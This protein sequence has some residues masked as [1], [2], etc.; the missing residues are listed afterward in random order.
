MEG[1]AAGPRGFGACVPVKMGALPRRR[2]RGK[3]PPPRKWPSR[4]E[5]ELA[6]IR[7]RVM[8]W[9]SVRPD[10][11]GLLPRADSEGGWTCLNRSLNGWTCQSAM[12]ASVRERVRHEI[13]REFALNYPRD[14][15]LRFGL[16]HIAYWKPMKTLRH[17]KCN[18]QAIFQVDYVH[19][20]EEDLIVCK[21]LELR[22]YPGLTRADMC[23]TYSCVIAPRQRRAV[24]LNVFDE[25]SDGG[26]ADAG[27]SNCGP[28]PS[29]KETL[30]R[31]LPPITLPWKDWIPD[32][33]ATPAHLTPAILALEDDPKRR[34]MQVAPA[35]G[36]QVAPRKAS[37]PGGRAPAPDGAGPAQLLVR[38][39]E[40]RG[41]LPMPVRHT[42]RELLDEESGRPVLLA[43]GPCCCTRDRCPSCRPQEGASGQPVGAGASER[44]RLAGPPGNAS[45]DAGSRPGSGGAGAAFAPF[46][47]PGNVLGAVTRDRG[48]GPRMQAAAAS[49]GAILPDFVGYEPE[50]ASSAA[51][52]ASMW[53]INLRKDPQPMAPADLRPT[54]GAA[55]VLRG[56]GP[57]TDPV[58]L[59]PP[60]RQLPAAC[61]CGCQDPDYGLHVCVK[62]NIRPKDEHEEAAASGIKK[63]TIHVPDIDSSAKAAGPVSTTGS[64][65]SSGGGPVVRFP[66]WSEKECPV[67]GLIIEYP[68][69][70]KPPGCSECDRSRAARSGLVSAA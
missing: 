63:K 44:G 6:K 57:A 56:G 35:I 18:L 60:K 67:C 17:P 24:Q 23:L 47:G 49:Y 53:Q 21:L 27:S 41:D 66:E 38:C 22:P 1:V 58:T 48:W 13:A 26:P 54:S 36:E 39:S 43:M 14:D 8:G 50:T 33:D 4:A 64:G 7:I 28:L 55:G 51:D 12:R 11:H 3:Q 2:L 37:A 25:E 52:H 29:A 5:R 32:V 16:S 30:R 19:P 68:R 62:R 20:V 61:D 65:S 59:L 9:A 42:V 31:I 40:C 15:P 34:C 10:C 45:W 69:G 46:S 70:T